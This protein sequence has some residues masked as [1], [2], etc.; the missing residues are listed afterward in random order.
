M[1]K[2]DR[3]TFLCGTAAVGA[4]RAFAAPRADQ[5]AP[6]FRTANA[7]WQA[8]Y[9]RA[10]AVLAAN[11]QILPRY[12]QPVL[13]EGANYAGIWMECGPHEALVYRKFRALDQYR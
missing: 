13:I 3:R 11:V 4:S 10:L 8:A 5:H 2:F 6:Q 1:H 9:D 12:N 7:R